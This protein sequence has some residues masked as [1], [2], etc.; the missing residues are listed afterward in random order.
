MQNKE[1][2]NSFIFDKVLCNIVNNSVTIKGDNKIGLLLEFCKNS[3][4][5]NMGDLMVDE[6]EKLVK[7]KLLEV[8][9]ET[10]FLSLEDA[11]NL[12]VGRYYKEHI[13]FIENKHKYT[14][15][16]DVN[17]DNDNELK[18]KLDLYN[19]VFV[20][21]DYKEVQSQV[22]QNASPTIKSE[23]EWQLNKTIPN[24]EIFVD[25]YGEL[26]IHLPNLE[27]KLVFGGYFI[28]DPIHCIIRTSQICRVFIYK[29]KRIFQAIAENDTQN[30]MSKF[31][32]IY[33]K[34]MTVG[35]ILSYD[36]ISFKEA[37]TTA[38]NRYLSITKMRSFKNQLD[39][40]TKDNSIK[41]MFTMIKL[42]VI[43]PNE[44]IN[45]AGLLFG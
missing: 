25:S 18:E 2:I 26:T 30:I 33:I 31:T 5:S 16:E 6:Y 7:P 20:I 22:P 45:V 29:K 3:K 27:K 39:D 10:G 42:L 19:S 32:D 15:N 13:D 34:N 4:I 1:Q 12:L 28:N 37:L 35:E 41:K 8:C 17:T 36:E 9:K 40:F 11:L 24:S 21:T 43:G 23:L 38:Y 14:D 44:C